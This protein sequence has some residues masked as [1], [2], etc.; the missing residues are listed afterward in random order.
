MINQHLRLDISFKIL[1]R[2]KLY[3]TT[4]K[5]I[6]YIFFFNLD[7]YYKNVHRNTCFQE[8]ILDLMIERE[9]TWTKYQAFSEEK[10]STPDFF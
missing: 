3:I 2:S 8:N 6:K 9:Q 4:S 5:N 10:S 1:C 7:F